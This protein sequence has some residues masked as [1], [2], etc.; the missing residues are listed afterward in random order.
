MNTIMLNGI[1]NAGTASFIQTRSH[2]KPT[3]YRIVIGDIN[4]LCYQYCD[5]C[6]DDI[7]FINKPLKIVIVFTI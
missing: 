6:T 3:I 7:R 5:S 1:A 4:E 2:I